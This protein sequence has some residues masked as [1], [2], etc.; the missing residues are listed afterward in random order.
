[1]HEF[2]HWVEQG[3]KQ[4]KIASNYTNKHV[5]MQT[6]VQQYKKQITPQQTC[7]DIIDMAILD[8]SI[9]IQHLQFLRSHQ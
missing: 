2:H 6:N 9:I 3:Q 5:K 8:E 1:M 7:G 4:A